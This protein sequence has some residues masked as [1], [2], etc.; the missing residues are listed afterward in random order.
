M[1]RFHAVQG[2]VGAGPGERH[3]MLEAAHRVL[4]AAEVTRVDRFDVPGRGGSE[5]GEGS[6]RPDVERLVPALQSGSLFGD[7]V[8]VL[9]VDAQNLLAN[10]AAALA[11][12][13]AAV[14]PETVA[15]VLVGMGAFP[16]PL[17][18]MVRAEADL[19]TVRELRERDVAGILAHMARQRRLRLEP[20]AVTSLL[21]RFGTDVGS[22]A[23]A[24]DQLGAVSDT[25]TAE[26]VTERFR[27]R[28]DEPLWHYV[29]AVSEGD[30]GAA[31]RRLADFL[32]HGHP[33]ALL[34][35]VEADL[36]RKALAASAP[37]VETLAGWLDSSP[38]HYPVTKAWKA[39]GSIDD[40]SL[41][42]AL[43][44]VARADVALKSEPEAT[45]RITMERLTV[46]LARWYTS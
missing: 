24:L 30:V 36:R 15:L 29:D 13:L 39:R 7:R 38:T 6:L 23:T 41:H 46:A 21:Q 1:A 34:A 14:D 25:V 32:T 12:L 4:A 22:L 9:V 11:G 45:H 33:L 2:P 20:A 26:A 19:H 17:A 8:G 10:E 3:E 16:G 40:R 35:A 27:N 44:A 18:A 5:E 28:P 31:L 37:S 42:A 43:Q